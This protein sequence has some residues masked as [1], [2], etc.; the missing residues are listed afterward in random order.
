MKMIS[1]FHQHYVELCSK[2]DARQQELQKLQHNVQRLERLHFH[3]KNKS[4]VQRLE[5]SVIEHQIRDLQYND[6][7]VSADDYDKIH[8][9]KAFMEKNLEA[10]MDEFVRI[11]KQIE[12]QC[13]AAQKEASHI[14]GIERALVCLEIEMQRLTERKHQQR[15]HTFTR[16]SSSIRR[17]FIDQLSSC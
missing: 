4:T 7:W 14:I 2:R 11:Q 1:I 8:E 15:S 16:S 5:L 17:L 12:E 6:I 10:I 3:I 9:N 13:E